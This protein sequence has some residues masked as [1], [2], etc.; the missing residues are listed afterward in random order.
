M[1]PDGTALDLLSRFDMSVRRG[2]L[3]G[4]PHWPGLIIIDRHM[5]APIEGR[6]SGSPSDLVLTNHGARLE[7]SPHRTADAIDRPCH[8]DCGVTR[9]FPRSR[10]AAH[11]QSNGYRRG[12]FG[13][14][15]AWRQDGSSTTRPGGDTSMAPAVSLRRHPLPISPCSTSCTERNCNNRSCRVRGDADWSG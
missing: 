6:G 1:P 15:A 5:T 11:G 13:R 14:P 7:N 8:I 12:K 4:L 3:P 9:C 2:R 10:G